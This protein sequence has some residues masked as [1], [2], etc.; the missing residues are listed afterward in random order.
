MKIT[1]TVM[2]L[3]ILLIVTPVFAECSLDHLIIGCNSDSVLGTDDDNKLFVD[4]SQKYRSSG[5]PEY[6]H[7]YYPLVESIFPVQ[8]KWSK[9]QPGFDA[10]Q[11]YNSNAAYTYDPNRCLAGNAV[12]DYNIVVDCVA[13]SPGLRA[14]F[15]D[16]PQYLHF[17]IE[18]NGQ[19]SFDYSEIHDAL[20]SHM[21][22]TYKAISGDDLLWITWR[23]VDTLD[24]GDQY[25]PS[26][27]FTIV[28]NAEPRS[29]DLFVDGSVDQGDLWRLGCYWLGR[30]GSR[31]N[32]YYERADADRN[33]R[34]DYL[35]FS[36]FAKSWNTT[37]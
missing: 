16:G 9:G 31:E 13:V 15:D 19:M 36:L 11:D 28:F 32:D 37:R 34:G 17:T 24:D 33:G 12:E 3:F 27:P 1:A 21:H 2:T 35:D 30:S 23:L 10:F 18:L 29:G 20:G 22:I 26:E 6:L 5:T 14:V 7:W 8:Y 4:C 25:L